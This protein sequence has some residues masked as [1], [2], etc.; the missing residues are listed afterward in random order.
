MSIKNR[1]PK[2]H[3]YPSSDQWY[4][5]GTDVGTNSSFTADTTWAGFYTVGTSAKYAGTAMQKFNVTVDGSQQWKIVAENYKPPCVHANMDWKT[6]KCADCD[7][8]AGEIQESFESDQKAWSLN[9]K[10]WEVN[11][12]IVRR[13][14]PTEFN[15]YIN[16]SDLLEEFIGFLGEHK[17]K[18]G[19]VLQLPLDLFIKWLIIQACEKDGEIA[20][21]TLQLPSGRRSVRCIG[22]QQYM[23]KLTQL[24]VHSPI[25]AN[26]YFERIQKNG[27]L[28]K[29]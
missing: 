11:K 12:N 14:P 28:A 6:F 2:F 19:E 8:T 23:P 26:F 24:P 17:V 20:P 21:V 13:A 5:F 27:T 9:K 18:Q 10:S 7:R 3:T 16:G 25:C 29:V 15:K 1:K 22:C 4:T